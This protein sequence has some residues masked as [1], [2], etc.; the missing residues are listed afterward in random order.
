MR[1]GGACSRAQRRIEVGH[2]VGGSIRRV[3]RD[4]LE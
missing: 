4:R 2:S 3:V 1:P